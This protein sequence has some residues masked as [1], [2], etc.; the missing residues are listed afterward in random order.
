VL[1]FRKLKFAPEHALQILHL[2][3][4]KYIVIADSETERV[5]RKKGV[6]ALRVFR[7]LW[8]VF[9][10]LVF[11]RLPLLLIICCLLRVLTISLSNSHQFSFQHPNPSRISGFPSLEMIRIVYL[12][13]VTSNT[14]NL[15]HKKRLTWPV[16]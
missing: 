9:P 8:R 13:H 5:N 16:S 6:S 14:H 1:A 10:S 7:A 2:G 4:M 3:V 12:V 15:T 11:R